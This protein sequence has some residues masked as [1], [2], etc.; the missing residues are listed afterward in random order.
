M[1]MP[2]IRRFDPADLVVVTDPSAYPTLEVLGPVV[3]ANEQ[4]VVVMVGGHIALA[5][6]RWALRKPPA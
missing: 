3:S 1:I 6:G 4:E 5:G 2:F